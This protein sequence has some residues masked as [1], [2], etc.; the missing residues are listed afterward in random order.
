M[1]I[2]EGD[3]SS[4]SLNHSFTEGGMKLSNFSEVKL[5]LD[6]VLALNCI[7]GAVAL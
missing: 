6:V 2:I 1:F 7:Y 3:W 5:T 4:L